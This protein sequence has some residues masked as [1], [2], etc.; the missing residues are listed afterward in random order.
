M[1]PREEFI[2]LMIENIR[3]NG[4]DETTARITAVLFLETEEISLEELAQ[5]TEYSLSSVS[6][7]IKFMEAAGLIHKFK[8]P[9]S[10]KVYLKMGNDIIEIMLEMLKKKQQ[11]IMQRSKSNLPTIISNYKKTK[12]SKQELKIIE[13]YY[14]DVLIGEQIIGEMIKKIEA[15]RG[16]Q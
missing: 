3:T 9:H 11:V 6:T 2:E 8:K 14:N 7:S 5:K 4:L 15:L 13:K 10:K 16:R 1:T 12:S